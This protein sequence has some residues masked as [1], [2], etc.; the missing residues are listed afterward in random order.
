M[1][2][3]SFIISRIGLIFIRFFDPS[4]ERMLSEDKSAE[5]QGFSQ[6]W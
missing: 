3:Y 2:D 4:R 6:W 5:E 1:L